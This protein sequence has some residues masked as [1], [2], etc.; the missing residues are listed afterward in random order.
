MDDSQRLPPESCVS[1]CYSRFIRFYPSSQSASRAPT[2]IWRDGLNSSKESPCIAFSCFSA[3]F[4]PL[5]TSTGFISLH[6][7]EF[8]K[9]RTL[10][11]QLMD[12]PG[13]R[14]R[15]T[16]CCSTRSLPSLSLSSS[17]LLRPR[18]STAWKATTPILLIFGYVQYITLSKR[19]S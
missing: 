5:M 15:G 18:V 17:A 2:Y 16:S 3:I 10:R 13:Y 6:S 1:P 9:E 12:Y 7:C 19:S 4:L 14:E 8:P 11:S